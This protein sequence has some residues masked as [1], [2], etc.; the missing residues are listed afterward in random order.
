MSTFDIITDAPGL[1]RS[2]ALNITIKFER[3]GPTTGRVSWNIPTPSAGCTAETQAYCGM[4]V[5]LDTKPASADKI[6]TNGQIYNSDPTA[7][8]NLFAGDKLGTSFVIGAFYNDRTTTFFD[9]DGL[10][11]NTPYY[12][13]G[14]PSDCQYRYFY[15]GVH[16]YSQEFKNRGSDDTNGTQVVELNADST[17]PGVKGSDVT[18]L[19]A[20]AIYDFTIQLGVEPK[21]NRPVGRDECHP[22]APQYHI[23]VDGTFAQ[24]YDDLVTEINKQFALLSGAVQGPYPPNTG[25]YYLKQTPP[26]QL[27]QWNGSA[28]VEIPLLVSVTAPTDVPVGTYWLNT[29]TNVLS[30]WDGTNWVTVSVI[31]FSTNPTTPIADKTYWFN[32]TQAYLWNGNTWCPVRTFIQ[33]TDPSL[34]VSPAPGSYWYNMDGDLFKWNNDLELW[35]ATTAVQSDVDPSALPDGYY[36]FD[37][38]RQKLYAYNTPNPGWN[39]QANVAISENEPLTPGPGKFW[40]NPSNEQL[41]QRNSANTAWDVLDCISFPADPTAHAYCDLWWDTLNDTLN[42]WDGVHSVWVEVATFYQQATDPAAAPEMQEGWVWYN[43]TDKVLQVWNGRCW[44]PTDYIFW[45]T[46]PTQTLPDGVVWHDTTHDKWYVKDSAGWTEI[47]PTDSPDDPRNLP[48]GTFWYNPTTKALMQ[49][50]GASWVAVAYSTVPLAPSKGTRWYDTDTNVLKEWNGITWVVAQPIAT[51]EL[52]CNGN[53]LFTDTKPG[54]TSFVSIKDGTL[55]K[56][57]DAK[58]NIAHPRPGTDGASDI[59]SYEEVGIGTDGSDAI[60]SQIANEIRYE[61]G[62]PVAT[63][64]LTKEQIDYAITRALNEIRSRTSI[65]YK[66]GFFFMKIL[67]SQQRYF[68]T[69]KVQ[70]MNKIVDVM[71]IYRMN[72]AFLSSAH[73]AGVY[74]QIVMQHMYNMGTFDLLSYHLMAEYTSLM[75]QLFAT[76]ITFNWN[77]QTRELMMFQR[78]TEPEPM[79][80]IEAA[81]ER[82]EQDIMSDRYIR[83]WIRKYAAAV[84]RLMLAEIRGRFSTLPGAGGNVSLNASDLRQAAQQAFEECEADIEDFITDKPDEYGMGAHFIFG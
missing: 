51:V 9:I 55:F 56:S 29:T 8:P 53:L 22:V 67:R 20:G 76:R 62:Y 75:E 73:G 39:E 35:E 74:G 46:D 27:F 23:E 36:W 38:T 57:L 11:A 14:F 43:P 41:Q 64:E 66:R 5:T 17:P 24:T 2:E 47:D 52:D 12:I 77:E 65:A 28:N 30:Q 16:A 71:G 80:L 69:N 54:S 10:K 61:L 68:L 18:G 13:T 58:T 63:V 7:D 3:T 34:A 48:A 60:R 79:V 21:P 49:W 72:S 78:F 70:G 45:N 26:Q 84:C 82:T 19:V 40:Y 42:V 44:V 15:E 31:A 6:P 4:L 25:G 37:E 81:C 33:T 83:P 32:G 59:P 1:L 50:N